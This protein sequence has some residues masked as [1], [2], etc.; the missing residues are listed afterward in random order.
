MVEIWADINST[1]DTPGAKYKLQV[2]QS[3][4]MFHCAKHRQTKPRFRSS[5]HP[6]FAL[7]GLW[8][9]TRHY[10]LKEKTQIYKL[11]AVLRDSVEAQQCSILIM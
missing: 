3:R 8:M 7:L 2:L 6:F 1:A 10:L 5:G 4:D 11:S 9:H